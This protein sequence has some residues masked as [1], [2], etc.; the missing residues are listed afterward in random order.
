MLTIYDTA[1]CKNLSCILV[2]SGSLIMS[3]LHKSQPTQN[4]F[5]PDSPNYYYFYFYY[6]SFRTK[7]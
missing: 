6:A 1:P 3:L 4:L 2:L 5:P 7:T